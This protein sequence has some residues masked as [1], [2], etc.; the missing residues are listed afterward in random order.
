MHINIMNVLFVIALNQS[1]S[2]QFRPGS[3]KDLSEIQLT[4]QERYKMN[5][6]LMALAAPCDL[7]TPSDPDL[8]TSEG[9]S[10]SNFILIS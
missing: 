7:S 3:I 9:S 4:W 8:A 2:P 1:R 5:H 6:T 10:A